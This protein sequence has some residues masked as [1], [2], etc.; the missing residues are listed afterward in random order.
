MSTKRRP[1]VSTDPHRRDAAQ[2]RRD[3]AIGMHRSITRRDFLHGM[4]A[5][6]GLLAACRTS[7]SRSPASSSGATGAA[8]TIPPES[9]APG[10]AADPFSQQMPEEFKL[11][12]DWY[13]PGGIGDYAPS[14]GNTPEVVTMAHRVRDGRFGAQFAQ[15]SDTGEAYDLIVVGGGFAGLAAA[16]HFRRLEGSGRCLIL[17]NHPIFGGEAKRNEF[18]VR[19]HRLVGP[20]GSNDFGIQPKTGA[21]DDYFTAL[22]LPREYDYLEPQ[23]PAAGMRLPLDNYSFLHWAADRFDVGYRFGDAT[24]SPGGSGSA[25]TGATAAG[26]TAAPGTGLL[27]RGRPGWERDPWSAATLA[28]RFDGKTRAAIA[29]WRDS[30]ADETEAF[31]RGAASRPESEIGPWLDGMTMKQYYEQVLALPPEITAYVDPILASIIGLGCD[32]ISAWWGWHFGLPGFRRSSRYTGLVF[33][34][35]PGGNAVIARHFVKSLIPESIGGAARF[36]DVVE[37]SVDFAA[38]DRPGQP[39]RLRLGSTVVRVEHRGPVDRSEKAVV[40]YFRDGALH[41]TT[42]K[43]VVMASGGWINRHVLADLPAGHRTAYESFRHSAV[44]VVNVALNHWR[45]LP[46]LGFGSCL[47]QGGLGFSCN[48][49]RPMHVGDD[50][51]ARL[52]PDDPIVLTLYIPSFTPGMPAKAQ[53][54]LGRLHL[55]TTSFPEVERRIREQLTLLFG[56]AGFDP[57]QDIAGIVLNRWGHAYVNPGPG[58]MFGVGGAEPVSAVIRK[59]FGRIAI[60][61]SELQGHQNWNGAAAEGRRAIEALLKA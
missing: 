44:L 28:A 38:L 36:A 7:G 25:G 43:K 37:Q 53:G 51:N 61:H 49:R 31:R 39:V 18:E 32:A 14:H 58:F 47:W 26:G 55:L 50:P 52:H 15:A 57:A 22:G 11:P 6:A 60:G 16:H 59:P 21:P 8:G 54:Q 35:Y 33:H 27:L 46:R 9:G 20:Q 34:C 45:F 1:P 3:A 56:E 17:D 23:G 13:G 29:R 2:A 41:R 48:V 42:A 4:P 24:P 5:L 10:G 12:A 19:G 30:A 40:T